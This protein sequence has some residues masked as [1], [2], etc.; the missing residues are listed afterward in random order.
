MA[1]SKLRAMRFE[2]FKIGFVNSPVDFWTVGYADCFVIVQASL[3]I[4]TIS[5]HAHSV[6][7]EMPMLTQLIHLSF[8]RVS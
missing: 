8:K 4:N 3:S 7:I 2:Q 5:L 6:H 1:I